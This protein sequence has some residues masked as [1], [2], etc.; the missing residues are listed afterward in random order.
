[1]DYLNRRARE[2]GEEPVKPLYTSSDAAAVLKLWKRT[3]YSQQVDLGKGVRFTFLDAGHI[4]G[5]AYVVLEI[6]EA[7]GTKRLLFTADIGRYNA[8]IIRDPVSPPG[9]FDWVITESTYGDRSHGPIENVGPQLL[10]AVKFCIEKRS[11]LLVP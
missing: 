11:R 1:A 10:D 6:D 2:P 3:P 7:G 5:S 4:L 8:P 9:V